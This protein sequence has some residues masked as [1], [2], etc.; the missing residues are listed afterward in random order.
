MKK[1]YLI[2]LACLFY[3]QIFAGEKQHI[4]SLD[5]INLT[6]RNAGFTL[7]EV[8]NATGE[9]TN[10]GYVEKT[11]SYKDVPAHLKTEISEELESFIQR[12]LNTADGTNQ[13]YLRVNTLRI[14]ETYDGVLE[15]ATVGLEM[16]FI[17][18]LETQYFEKLTVSKVISKAA[19]M[20]I[21]KQQPALI[22]QALVES[23][24]DFYMRSKS[25]KLINK[26]IAEEDLYTRPEDDAFLL[27]SIMHADRSERGIYATY[28]DFKENTPDTATPF[29][30]E[31]KTKSSGDETIHIKHA[32]ITHKQ[33]GEKIED[34]WGFT[35]GSAVYLA[36]GKK[37]LPL[38]KDEEGYFLELKV[39]DQSSMTMAGAAGGLLGSSIAYAATP[40]SKV[41]LQLKSGLLDYNNQVEIIPGNGRAVYAITFFSSAY[42]KPESKLE[43]FINEEFQCVLTK[44]TWFEYELDGFGETVRVTL[45]SSNG[46]A[47][48]ETM[49]TVTNNEDLYLCIDKKKKAPQLNKVTKNNLSGIKELM[50]PDNRIYENETPAGNSNQ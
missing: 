8:T 17:Y 40:K 50:N 7:V 49:Q 21:S 2:M 28:L 33:T 10:I 34:I 35:D 18:K 12:N 43:L 47:T 36:V 32:R 16:T 44:E 1:P 5:K 14:S 24:D 27:E 38:Q 9:Q 6:I 13:M 11:I 42:N 30:L 39:V 31:Y 29:D 45:K 20:G 4:I 22:A 15:T 46:L 41:R 26:N 37:F 3:L 19:S 25:G 23:F 48:E